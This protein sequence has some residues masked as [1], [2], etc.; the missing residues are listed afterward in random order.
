V[1]LPAKLLADGER[2][3]VVLRPHVRRLARPTLL[4]LV[5]A[6]LA[7]Y[8]VAAVPRSAVQVPARVVVATLAALVAVRWVVLPFLTWWN[9]LYVLTDERVLVRQGVVRR[10]GH[11]LPLRGV[12]DVLVAQRLGERLLR[13]G[14]LTVTTGGSRDLVLNDVPSVVRLQRSLLAAADQVA[15]RVRAAYEQMR[16]ADAHQLADEAGDADAGVGEALADE[17]G[18][19]LAGGW[20]GTAWDLDPWDDEAPEA[21]SRREARRRDRESARRLKALQAEVRRAPRADSPLEDD[22]LEGD[23]LERAQARR[24]ASGS[25]GDDAHPAEEEQ[26]AQGAQILRFPRRP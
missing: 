22:G 15:Q 20:D 18:D 16:A 1:G 6:P 14:T 13:S 17:L 8:A 3:L 21:P 12:T 25:D 19:E 5:L 11:D 4:L 23:G 10:T 9:T 2:P 24:P 26:E 7:S